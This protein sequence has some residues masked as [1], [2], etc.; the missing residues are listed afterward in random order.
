[1]A[2][3]SGRRGDFLGTDDTTGFTEY[4]S[5]LR[6]DYWGNRTA[7]PL[8]RNL[9]ELASPLA[10][11]FPLP[12]Y[13]GPSYEDTPAGIG[14]VLTSFVGNTT[15][16]TNPNNMAAQVLWTTNGVPVVDLAIPDMAIGT[17]FNVR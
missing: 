14:T 6:L 4:G 3:R 9:Q 12:F 10:D 8:K 15:V 2:R 1:M 5:K 16:P 7:H 11:P 17:T 13:R